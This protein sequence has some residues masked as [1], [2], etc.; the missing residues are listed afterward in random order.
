MSHRRSTSDS[1]APIFVAHDL[2]F[3]GQGEEKDQYNAAQRYDWDDVPPKLT[4]PRVPYEVTQP[5]DYAAPKKLKVLGS[6]ENLVA[7]ARRS[8]RT[9][10][11]E[12]TPVAS[13]SELVRQPTKKRGRPR[14]S[15]AS[16]K[17]DDGDNTEDESYIETTHGTKRRPQVRILS[18]P[19]ELLLLFAPATTC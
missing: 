18:Y 9:R 12:N 5:F 14:R 3:A 15:E 2:Q 7:A 10:K 19:T 6:A 8:T 1:T 16:K 11:D 4:E 13:E 17:T